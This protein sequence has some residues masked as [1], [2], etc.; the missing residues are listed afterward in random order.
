MINI[1]MNEFRFILFEVLFLIVEF[2]FIVMF[3]FNC[4]VN[5]WRKIDVVVYIYLFVCVGL[6]WN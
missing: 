1:F 6:V 4:I 3:E 2:G 5:S